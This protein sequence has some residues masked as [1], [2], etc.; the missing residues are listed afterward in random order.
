MSEAR[1]SRDVEIDARQNELARLE[2][3]RVDAQRTLGENL[4]QADR[5]I[6]LAHELAAGTRPAKQ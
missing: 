1:S 6:R 5:L 3:L 2:R 4:E